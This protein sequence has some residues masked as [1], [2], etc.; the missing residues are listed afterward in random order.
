[1]VWQEEHTIRPVATMRDMIDLDNG[2]LNS[3][4]HSSYRHLSKKSNEVFFS[5]CF[6][7]R[8]FIFAIFLIKMDKILVPIFPHLQP[9]LGWFDAWALGETNKTWFKVLTRSNPLCTAHEI[10]YEIFYPMIIV[11]D[12]THDNR[13]KHWI[14][15]WTVLVNIYWMRNDE[16]LHRWLTE[17][18]KPRHTRRPYYSHSLIILHNNTMKSGDQIISLPRTKDKWQHFFNQLTLGDPMGILVHDCFANY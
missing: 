5:R 8:D 13:S 11:K 17:G 12:P 14:W 4:V 1:M 7:F 16:L 3:Y 15:P 2:R 6:I 10:Y 18:I 9:F